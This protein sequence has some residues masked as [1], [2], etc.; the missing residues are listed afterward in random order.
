MG[1]MVVVVTA[2]SGTKYPIT[3]NKK[4]LEQAIN[5]KKLSRCSELNLI[6]E[7]HESM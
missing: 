4:S 5:K 6:G 3:K 2:A 7:F 1:F